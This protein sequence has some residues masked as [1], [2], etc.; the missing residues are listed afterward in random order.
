MQYLKVVSFRNFNECTYRIQII[1]LALRA[2]VSIKIVYNVFSVFV[3]YPMG[4]RSCCFVQSHNSELWNVD[5]VTK[6]HV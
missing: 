4:A 2:V 3:A 6:N 1:V 5:V